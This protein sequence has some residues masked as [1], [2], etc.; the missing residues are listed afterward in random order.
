MCVKTVP[1]SEAA[2]A[3]TAVL[4]KRSKRFGVGKEI[5]GA[6]YVH[7]VYEAKLGELVADAKQHLPENTDYHVVKLNLRTRCVSFVQCLDFDTAAEPTVG[8]MV[9]VD[10]EGKVRRRSQS[11]DPEIY[12]HKWLFVAADYKGFDV[13]ASKQRS[14]SWVSLENVDR[15]RIGRKSYWE[16]QVAPRLDEES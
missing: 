10:A 7:R 11:R 13:E 2:G 4:P 1:T 14:L 8:N 12:H 15:T 3:M 16:Q 5:G 6:V 9:T